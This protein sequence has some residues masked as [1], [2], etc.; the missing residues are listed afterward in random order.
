MK[1]FLVSIIL[2]SLFILPA[3][4]AKKEVTLVKPL[5][6]YEL[7]KLNL[8]SHYY[9][10]YRVSERIIRANALNDRSWSVQIAAGSVAKNR[11]IVIAPEQFDNISDDISGLA[12]LIA[13]EIA[14]SSMNI[15][16]KLDLNVKNFKQENASLERFYS[17]NPDSKASYSLSAGK[18]MVFHS[19]EPLN[20]VEDG[21]I[22]KEERQ[23]V[24]NSKF[25]E[26]LKKLE[27]EADSKALVYMVK[28]GFSP[29]NLN[30]TVDFTDKIYQDSAYVSPSGEIRILNLK[31][32]LAEI[33]TAQLKK[34]GELNLKKNRPLKFERSA[35]G[36]SITINSKYGS[37]D[38][39]DWLFEH[40]FKY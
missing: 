3:N 36:K 31:N 15:E 23:K 2:I 39:T 14:F 24:I 4:A 37:S 40:K 29:L 33:N 32:K 30:R 8:D 25:Y 5:T 21:R 11:T 1:K 17:E 28:A 16:E 22:E 13:R 26:T 12:F 6:L 35:N 18:K 9:R 27:Y 38:N 19:T 20:S 7:A 34:E 10:L